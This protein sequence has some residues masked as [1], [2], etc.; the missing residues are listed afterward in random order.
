[1]GGIEQLQDAL[2]AAPTAAQVVVKARRRQ[3]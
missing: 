2:L 3:R 1:M